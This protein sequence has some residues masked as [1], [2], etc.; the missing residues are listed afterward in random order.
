MSSRKK[1]R[2]WTVPP[3]VSWL[4]WPVFRRSWSRSGYSHD[5]STIYVL[6]GVGTYGIGPVLK[7]ERS[8]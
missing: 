6:R 2:R 5:R 7:V 1:R 4:L 3:L 8:S